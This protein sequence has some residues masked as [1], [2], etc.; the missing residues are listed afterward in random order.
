MNI[1]TNTSLNSK[2]I[3]IAQKV[4]ARDYNDRERAT[5]GEVHGCVTTGEA[6]Q[7]L[8]GNAIECYNLGRFGIDN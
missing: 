5:V 6:W 8:R 1:S 3:G 7:F 2:L 4:A